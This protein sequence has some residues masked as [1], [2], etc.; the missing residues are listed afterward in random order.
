MNPS[1]IELVTKE[2]KSC[3]DTYG[4]VA[5]THHYSD[6]WTR[7]AYFGW[8]S[9]LEIGDTQI[10]KNH[11]SN[12]SKFQKSSGLIP[13]ML[14]QNIPGLP[15]FGIKKHIKPFPKYRS[16]KA[17]YTSN[18]IDSNAYFVIGFFDYLKK[19][20]DFDFVTENLENI[21]LALNWYK[22]RQNNSLLVNEGLIAQWNDGVYKRGYVLVTNIQVYYAHY[23]YALLLQMLNKDSSEAFNFAKEIKEQIIKTYWEDSYFIDWVNRNKRYKYFDTIANMLAI[24]WGVADES[25]QNSIL[26]FSK[27]HVYDVPLAKVCFPSYPSRLVELTNK[28]FG[29]GGYWQGKDVYWIEPSL[30][31]CLALQKSGRVMEAEAVLKDV[32]SLINKDSGVFETYKLHNQIFAPLK[33]LFYVSEHPYARG[34]G[35][36]LHACKTLGST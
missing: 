14:R 13:F 2:L 31:Y 17:L 20:N 10:V 7:D 36:Y 11:L 16:H 3:Y 28:L 33:S 25:M 30:L 22:Q 24:I 1:V 21:T 27:D 6:Y 26:E 29:V 4:I 32:S 19:T 9:A 35:L 8:L 5:G 34:A 23:T 12:L 18:V 15:F